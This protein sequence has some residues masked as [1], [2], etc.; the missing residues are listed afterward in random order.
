MTASTTTLTPAATTE[1]AKTPIVS[2]FE[3]FGE[4]GILS[5]RLGARLVLRRMSFAS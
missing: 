3:W 5:A 4:L 1:P 2:V